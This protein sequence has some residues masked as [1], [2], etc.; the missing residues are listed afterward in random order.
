M[1]QDSI[2]QLI[3]EGLSISGPRPST[4][5]PALTLA[6]SPSASLVF[7][8]PGP[9]FVFIG[10]DPQFLF[11]QIFAISSEPEL[12]HTLFPQLVFTGPGTRFVLPLRDL[13]LHLS[14]YW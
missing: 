12:S 4:W 10:P 6:P 3:F 1:K 8:G 14:F 11:T 9:Q 5:K 13:H 7:T 2:I